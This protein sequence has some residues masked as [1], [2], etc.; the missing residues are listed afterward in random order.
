M[1]WRYI[2][3]SS[4]WREAFSLNKKNTSFKFP[5]CF[6]MSKNPRAAAITT[7]PMKNWDPEE[8][9]PNLQSL[10]TTSKRRSRNGRSNLNFPHAWGSSEFNFNF[11]FLGEKPLKTNILNPKPWRF[12]RW[13]SFSKGWFSGSML[14]FG[15]Y[16][17][18]FF[19]MI[20]YPLRDFFWT[21]WQFQRFVP[22]TNQQEMRL[23]LGISLLCY[24]WYF[25]N[26]ESAPVEKGSLSHCFSRV[27][28]P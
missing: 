8:P 5:T 13:F 20:V 28:Y 7:L 24:C 16:T 3:K 17:G 2:C 21:Y 19:S 23:S 27:N 12:G 18:G 11:F 22:Q 6:F 1:Y 10:G 15:G 14:L 26:P 9:K 4:T 25:R